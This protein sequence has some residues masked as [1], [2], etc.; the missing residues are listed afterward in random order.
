VRNIVASTTLRA[1]VSSDGIEADGMSGGV[2]SI[3]ATG[4]Y[5]SFWSQATNLVPVD[6]NGVV[7]DIFVHDS[8]AVPLIYCTAKTNSLGCVGVIGY[9]GVPMTSFPQGFVVTAS[10]LLNQKL[11]LLL[12]STMGAASSPL[13]GG[14]LCVHQPFRRTP[15]QFSGG[16]TSGSDCTGTYAYDFNRLIA[17]GSDS[18]LAAGQQVWAQYWSRD[19]GFAPPNNFDLTDALTF[20]IDP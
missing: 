14:T 20:V 11:G 16:S 17:S 5:V 7:E 19:P 1:S 13:H 10:G 3:S 4:R 6:D 2:L 9:S 12:Y 15:R 8:A 18:A